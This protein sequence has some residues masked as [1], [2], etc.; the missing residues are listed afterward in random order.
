MTYDEQ[1]F[2]TPADDHPDYCP[3]CGEEGEDCHCEEDRDDH[4]DHLMHARQDD[5]LD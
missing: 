3:D 1:I 5:A 4:G 2:R